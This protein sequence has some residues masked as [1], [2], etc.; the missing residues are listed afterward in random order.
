M[1]DP[2]HN[3]SKLLWFVLCAVAGVVFLAVGKYVLGEAIVV[4]SLIAIRAISQG[5]NP[6]WIRSPLDRRKPPGS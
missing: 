5:R 1:G 3:R 6:W 2:A 4:A